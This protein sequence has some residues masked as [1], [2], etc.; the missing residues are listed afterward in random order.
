[1]D[2]RFVCIQFKSKKLKE[3]LSKYN[4]QYWKSNSKWD[5]YYNDEEISCS[6]IRQDSVEGAL[7]WFMEE[8]LYM[9]NSSNKYIEEYRAN[10]QMYVDD[11]TAL[12]YTLDGNNY[13]DFSELAEKQ[14]S[15]HLKKVPTK[16]PGAN[17][18]KI[19][20][21]KLV[22][23]IGDDSEVIIPDK[24]KVIGANAFY[25]C[26][27][28]KS[29]V[30][31]DSVTDIEN[32]AFFVCTGLT[33]IIIPDSVIRI[34]GFA[35]ASCT[36]L[37]EIKIPDSVETIGASAFSN[38]TGL[39]IITIPK[40]VK[41]IG[42]GAFSFCDSLQRVN[43]TDLDSWCNIQYKDGAP[44]LTYDEL[45]VDGEKATSIAIPDSITN[46]S[47]FAFCGYRGLTNITIPDSVKSIGM[48]AF[49]LCE[50]LT[51][52]TIPDSVTCIGNNAFSG[53]KGL[54]RIMIPNNVTS[55]GESL[56][57]GC[58]N[59][60]DITLPDNIMGIGAFMFAGCGSIAQ[61]T[62]PQGVTRI[63]MYAF[64]R[65]VSLKGIIIPDGVNEIG[66]RA[67]EGC[68][69]LSSVEIPS[70]VT[71]IGDHAFSECSSLTS[72]TIPEGVTEVCVSDFD[73]T[74]MVILEK[75]IPGIEK[76]KKLK[77]LIIKSTPL[78]EIKSTNAKK[79]AVEGFQSVDDKS[80][81][82][83]D[84]LESYKKYIKG[85]K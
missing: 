68:S 26:G 8:L 2:I 20:S 84:V 85:K 55:I 79:L 58:T 48:S 82:D 61:I 56:F 40:S 1:M 41:S 9:M 75:Y 37:T 46:I 69:S 32:W 65:C 74:T 42:I 14:K 7:D 6:A 3:L 49:W 73:P 23:Y 60:T 57:S 17:S 34:G 78:N 25:K 67:F 39:K 12:N 81:Y 16:K 5:V 63:G 33:E 70:S 64:S 10:R 21:G 24:V 62:I 19:K 28:L 35:F 44:G 30:I 22:K 45:W 47:D 59:L 29:V 13:G 11:V 53:C 52:I 76:D 27:N 71:K 50:S 18:F 38:C 72:I 4:V 54:K 36:G 15:L 31:P 83:D 51:G 66:S 80:I 43:I 77:R